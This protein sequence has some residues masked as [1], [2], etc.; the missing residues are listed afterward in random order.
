MICVVFL[1][2]CVWAR[3]SDLFC[4]WLWGVVLWFS[5][6]VCLLRSCVSWCVLIICWLLVVVVS[7]VSFFFVLVVFFVLG[8]FL[9]LLWPFSCCFVSGSWFL[10]VDSSLCFCVCVCVCGVRVLVSVFVFS[11]SVVGFR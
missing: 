6:F 9:R 2:L 7:V 11:V 3:F 1:V 8:L 5:V 10:G 4:C